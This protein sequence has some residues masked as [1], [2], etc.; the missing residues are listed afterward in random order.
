MK[1]TRL[2]QNLSF[3]FLLASAIVSRIL[4]DDMGVINLI[5]KYILWFSFGLWL[6]V[7]LLYYVMRKDIDNAH[8]QFENKR[9]NRSVRAVSKLEEPSVQLDSEYNPN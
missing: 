3:V 2:V 6:G 7:L 9:K 1:L 8:K 4:L 5:S